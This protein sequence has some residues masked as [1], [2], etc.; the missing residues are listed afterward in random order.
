MGLTCTECE[1][2]KIVCDAMSCDNMV[3]HNTIE[4]RDR[5]IV[6]L[7]NNVQT[8][9][10]YNDHL[11]NIIQTRDEYIKTL[12]VNNEKCNYNINYMNERKAK[13]EQ[14]IDDLQAQVK[15][16][17]QQLDDTKVA[18]RRANGRH[19]A[20]VKP[21]KLAGQ[22]RHRDQINIDGVM[23]DT[24]DLDPTRIFEIPKLDAFGWCKYD[25]R[26]LRGNKCNFA[27]RRHM[28]EMTQEH[29]TWQPLHSV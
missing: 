23:Y 8:H 21:D 17:H 28:P 27:H 18:L 9:F 16:L 7:S 19:S 5:R 22:R 10:Y 11:T 3:L 4:E 26:C 6:E 13:R 20:L 1:I 2:T 24:S 29:I 12:I 25:G 14:Y 15:K